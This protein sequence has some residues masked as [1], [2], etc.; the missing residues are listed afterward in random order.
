MKRQQYQSVDEYIASFPSK[1]QAILEELRQTIRKT[2]PQA[3]EKISYRIPT[4]KLHRN[5]VRFAAYEKHIGFYPT[6]SGIRAF[7]KQISAYKSSKG[8]VQFPIDESLPL[9]LIVRIVKF[10]VKEE[11]ARK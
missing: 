3:E 8:A 6:S 1:V 4:F 10:R 9:A 7:Q 11:S 2:V 5:L